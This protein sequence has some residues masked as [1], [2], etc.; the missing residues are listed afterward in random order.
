MTSRPAQ[1][2]VNSPEQMMKLRL[3]VPGPSK[4]S[5]VSAEV[6]SMSSRRTLAG[7]TLSPTATANVTMIAPVG[8][9]FVL[10]GS[11]RN[12]FNVEYADPVSDQ[13]LQDV[14][15]QNGRTLRVGLTW[16]FLSK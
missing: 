7:D 3:S 8:P 11:A 4:R 10:V 5:F 6:L 2:L 14:I 16:K 15:A 9:A 1:T 12:L 13:N